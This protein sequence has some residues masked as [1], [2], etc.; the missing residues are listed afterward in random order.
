M[1]GSPRNTLCNSFAH[2]SIITGFTA[3]SWTG[4]SS[5][6]RS[7]TVLLLAIARRPSASMGESACC[8]RL[9]EAVGSCGA[10]AERAESGRY[11]LIMGWLMVGGTIGGTGSLL[12]A[13]GSR[14]G[15]WCDRRS[16][17]QLSGRAFAS[18]LSR[19]SAA[20]QDCEDHHCGEAV[21]VGA[22]GGGLDGCRSLR[23]CS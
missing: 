3:L 21:A 2:A 9:G 8:D 14:R 23:S 4:T 20:S 11:E 5:S 10:R 13:G 17:R 22:S 6:V 16:A 1:V 12:R 7:Y 18:R 15:T 19:L